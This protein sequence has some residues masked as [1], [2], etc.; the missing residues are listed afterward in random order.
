VTA[1]PSPPRLQVAVADVY[2]AFARYRQP[3]RPLDVCLACCVSEEID[4]QLCEWPLKRLT[5]RHFYEYNGSAKSA[6]QNP[7]EVGYFLPRMLELLES[8][9]RIFI[10]PLNSRLIGWDGVRRAVGRGMSR[11]H[12]PATHT[13]ASTWYFVA[14][15]C[16]RSSNGAGGGCGKDAA[17]CQKDE[18]AGRAVETPGA[19]RRQTASALLR[20]SSLALAP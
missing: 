8:T 3:L 9:E 7:R 14:G 18:D 10:I 16:V 19:W 6:V 4:K 1:I 15:L 12:C 2:R 11:L 17:A 13:R 20:P 5:A